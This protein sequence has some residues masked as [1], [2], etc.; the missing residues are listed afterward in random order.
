M[1]DELCFVLD[2]IQS[3]YV[4]PALHNHI[5][6]LGEVSLLCFESNTQT[7]RFQ[8]VR[9]KGS[10]V[11]Q[12]VFCAHLYIKQ[13][14]SKLMPLLTLFW[15][16]VCLLSLRLTRFV[17]LITI[18]NT[19]II[20]QKSR[21]FINYG[22]VTSSTQNCTQHSTFSLSLSLSLS[23]LSFSLSFSNSLYATIAQHF[24]VVSVYLWYNQKIRINRE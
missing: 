6:V 13:I 12:V 20:N 19:N 11:F 15:Y 8:S 2:L 18:I 7:W 21:Q 24:N 5:T 16:V 22:N 10:A 23:L 17:F 1:E 14:M 3:G 9:V 4:W